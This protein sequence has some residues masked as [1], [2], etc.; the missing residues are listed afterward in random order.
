MY[1]ESKK[2]ASSGANDHTGVFVNKRQVIHCT[3]LL[4]DIGIT[5]AEGWTS[6]PPTYFSA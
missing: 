2:G 6:D 1:Q 3:Y 4:N 5:N